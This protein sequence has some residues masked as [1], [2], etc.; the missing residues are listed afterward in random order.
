MFKRTGELTDSIT[1][2]LIP[3]QDGE[4]P[5]ASDLGIKACIKPKGN[6]N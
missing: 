5:V 4:I 6:I 1:V 2:E 3:E